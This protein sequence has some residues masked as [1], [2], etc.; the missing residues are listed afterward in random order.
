M[1]EETLTGK[2]S[3]SADGSCLFDETGVL[4]SIP[5][6]P[7]QTLSAR[8][9]LGLFRTEKRE[10][11]P[12]FQKITQQGKCE[13][14]ASPRP[15]IQTTNSIV[16]GQD[17]H[18]N[19][20]LSVLRQFE[21]EGTIVLHTFCEDG[22]MRSE[23]LTRLPKSLKGISDAMLINP[24]PGEAPENL[25]I[26]LNKPPQAMYPVRD[27]YEIP[28]PAIIERTR[29]SIPMFVGHLQMSLEDAVSTS[30]RPGLTGARQVGDGMSEQIEES[31]GAK[32]GKSRADSLRR[33]SWAAE[34]S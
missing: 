28:L 17:A 24:A 20:T 21:S 9:A 15:P 32:R 3:F 10:R 19:N 18:G 34:S 6:T 31:L 30:R 1:I 23:M 25:R 26:V 5:Y 29:S 16:R 33:P 7:P 11:W 14:A 8:E 22:T 4:V 13:I 27:D 2:L 12:F